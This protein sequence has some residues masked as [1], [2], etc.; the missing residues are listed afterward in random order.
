MAFKPNTDDMRNAPAV[1][2]IHMLQEEGAKIKAYDPQAMG[3][4]KKILRGVQFCKDPY[5]AAKDSNC[6]LLLTEWPEFR[7]LD[8]KKIRGLME[9]PIIFDGR[10]LFHKYNLEELGFEY[11]GIG[12]GK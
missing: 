10:N 4:S 3:N 1:D 9:Q 12:R 2:I 6:L 8:F 5:A 11:Y 7:A